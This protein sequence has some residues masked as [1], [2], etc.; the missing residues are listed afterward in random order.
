M[1]DSQLYLVVKFLEHFNL[2]V[3]A[4]LAKEMVEL[5]EN[6]KLSLVLYSLECFNIL[7]NVEIF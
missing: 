4:E 7:Q 5:T 1:E 3:M 6:A 2:L